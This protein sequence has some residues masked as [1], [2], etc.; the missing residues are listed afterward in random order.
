MDTAGACFDLIA[1]YSCA[2][3]VSKDDTFTDANSLALSLFGRSVVVE[4]SQFI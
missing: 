1:Q 2:R 4:C 3:S